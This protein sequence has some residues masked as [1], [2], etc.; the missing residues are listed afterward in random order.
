MKVKT[1]IML[2]YYSNV[3]IGLPIYFVLCLLINVGKMLARAWKFTVYETKD[4]YRSNRRH[5]GLT[6]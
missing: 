2:S 3:L 4:T 5:H 1:K 6:K